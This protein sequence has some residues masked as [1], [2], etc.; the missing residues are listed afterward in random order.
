MKNIL[1]NCQK[2][3]VFIFILHHQKSIK[4]KRTRSIEKK[5]LLLFSLRA[6]MG[7]SNF[8]KLAELPQNSTLLSVCPLSL[9]QLWNVQDRTR[10]FFTTI[11]QRITT[12]NTGERFSAQI[13]CQTVGI[14]SVQFI[15]NHTIILFSLV[16][17]NKTS[18]HPF[19]S[20]ETA[21]AFINKFGVIV[22]PNDDRQSIS[23]TTIT[24]SGKWINVRDYL[25]N[26]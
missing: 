8:I 15:S 22:I 12:V 16:E 18:G 21:C 5:Q 25:E 9:I 6:I 10:M 4:V 19:H 14:S 7:D 1:E 20:A 2:S 17:G 26:L 24:S 3:A 11:T 13:W 23:I